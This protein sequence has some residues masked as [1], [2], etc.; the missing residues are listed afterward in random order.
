MKKL[1]TLFTISMLAIGM[2]QAQ[3][4]PITFDSDIIVGENWKAD[5]G[6]ESVTVADDPTSSGKGKVGAITS[7]SAGQKWQNAQ[8]QLNT[9]YIDLTTSTG[10]KTITVDVYS[11]GAQDFLFKLEQSLNGG[12]NVE[13]PFSKQ[14]A[15]WETIAVDFT[16]TGVDDQYKLLVFFPCYST[17]FANDPFDGV[18]YIDNVTGVVGAAS[19]PPAVISFPIDFETVVGSSDFNNFDGGLA[20]VIDNPQGSGKV[21][22]MVRNGGQV[23]AGSWLGMSENIDFTTKK[24]I[25]MDV[26]TEAPIGTKI[27]LK[28]EGGALAE[29]PAFTTKTGEW[30]TMSWDFTGTANDN[31][32]LVFLFDLGNTGDGSATSTFLFDNITHTESVPTAIGD[33]EIEKL[34]LYPNPVSDVLN[35]KGLDEGV[36]IEIYNAAGSLV[37]KVSVS[38]GTVNVSELAKGVYFVS[39]NGAIAKIIKK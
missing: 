32:K 8:L 16:S 28:V 36:S 3:S 22:Q 21:A 26:Y 31:F 7:S 2:A 5:S 12:P 18:T 6:L 24:I 10:S 11:D 23:W 20:T 1:F 34:D 19:T 14:G 35:I 17:D 39:S 27:A 37:K 13:I 29:I 25:S 9:N 4:I 30:E 15:G 33:T 38:G